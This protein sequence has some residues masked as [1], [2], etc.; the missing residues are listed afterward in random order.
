MTPDQPVPL[1]GGQHWRD[2]SGDVIVL[3]AATVN[4]Q[5]WSAFVVKTGALVPLS[6]DYIRD[7]YDLV[8]DDPATS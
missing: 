2:S 3:K 6:E 5:M 4:R 7:N 1:K 8:D